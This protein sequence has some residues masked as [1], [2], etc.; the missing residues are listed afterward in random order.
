[1]TF[2]TIYDI[3][4][5]NFRLKPDIVVKD[6]ILYIRVKGIDNVSLAKYILEETDNFRITVKEREGYKFSDIEWIKIESNEASEIVYTGD[7]N[8]CFY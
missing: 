7:R 4:E 8:T 1:L 6:D 2:S 3:I 5:N